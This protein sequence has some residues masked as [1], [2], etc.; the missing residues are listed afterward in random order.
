MYVWGYGYIKHIYTR[1][2]TY[3]YFSEICNWL[4]IEARER[5][6]G[7]KGKIIHSQTQKIIVN[8]LEFMKADATNGSSLISLAN[9]K[10][11]L[12]TA[13]KISEMSY[14]RIVKESKEV[15]SE[16]ST[17][18]STPWKQRPCKKIK[19]FWLSLFILYLLCNI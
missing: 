17:S 15:Q 19:N 13:T 14:N 11:R 10:A 7:S 2:N 8:V 12:P 16:A 4:K 9:L 6:I 5:T 3:L 18:I 1:M